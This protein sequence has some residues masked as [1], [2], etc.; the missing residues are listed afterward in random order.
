MSSSDQATDQ[1]AF[2]REIYLRFCEQAGPD[3]WDWQKLANKAF[4]AAQNFDPVAAQWLNPQA[5]VP[6]DAPSP[7]PN[8]VP[9][10]TPTGPPPGPVPAS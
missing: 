2:A 6:L 4:E 7:A 10:T 1:K 5:A 3:Q 9:E 8:P